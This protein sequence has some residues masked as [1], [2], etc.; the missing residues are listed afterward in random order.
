MLGGPLHLIPNKGLFYFSVASFKKQK[1]DLNTNFKGGYHY[2]TICKW[3]ME[4]QDA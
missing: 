1:K 2:L 4:S 3:G